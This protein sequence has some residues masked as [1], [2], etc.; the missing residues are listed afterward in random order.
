MAERLQEQKLAIE[1]Y[2]F[3]YKKDLVLE[4]SQ[5]DLLSSLIEVLRPFYAATNQIC[6]S[7]LS[8][9]LP[10]AR[11]L[12]DDDSISRVPVESE[13]YFGI[14]ATREILAKKFFPLEE[15][16]FSIPAFF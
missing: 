5:W 14:E 16:R 1:L 4:Q 11:L 7:P 3:R 9:Q 8:A 12:Y 2:A 13:L 10:I 15:D 6:S